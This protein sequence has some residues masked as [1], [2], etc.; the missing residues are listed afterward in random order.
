MAEPLV[1]GA[2]LVLKLVLPGPDRPR[3]RA[4]VTGWAE[5]RVTLHA[6]ALCLYEVTSALSRAVQMGTLTADEGRRTLDLIR[7]LGVELVSPDEDQA[8]SALEW[9]LR[10]K[11]AAAYDSSCLA[12]AEALQCELWTADRRLQNAAGVLWVHCA[13]NA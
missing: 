9:A 13:T 3:L 2:S 1:V 4:L 6:P 8:L 12:L 5:E 7:A 11:R 10:L